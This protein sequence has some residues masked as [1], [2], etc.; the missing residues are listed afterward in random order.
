MLEMLASAA[1]NLI[2]GAVGAWQKSKD[3]DMQKEFA[4]SGIQWKVK[5]AKKAGVHPLYA[6]GASTHSF[7][8]VSTGSADLSTAIP[9][10]GQD[11][12]RAIAST[13]DQSTRLNSYTTAIQKMSL[14]RGA[15]ENDLLRSQIA[16]MNMTSPA[17]P[18]PGGR[19]LID[20]Q[21]STAL[22]GSL[23]ETTPMSRFASAPEALWQEPGAITDVGHSRTASGGYAPVMSH[24][25]KQRLE[26]DLP[27]MLLWNIRNRL[28]P[29]IGMNQSPPP[30]TLP[31]GYDAWLYNPFKQEYT[32]HKRSRI[33]VYY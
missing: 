8:P 22:P 16:K 3:R 33:G 5:D 9:A 2:G 18:G 21:G 20:G 28:L 19:Y 6:L 32:P 1:S 7:A 14:E 4:Q 25:V 29:S 24:D 13:S 23:V 30:A 26:E 31:K 10:A 12:S 17:M 15:L 11:I 27:G